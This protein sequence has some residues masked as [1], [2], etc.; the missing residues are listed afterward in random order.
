MPKPKPADDAVA[1]ALATADAV[2]NL[3]DV[4]GLIH[5]EIRTSNGAQRVGAEGRPINT[6]LTSQKLSSSGGRLAGWSVRETS[7][8][9]PAV[10]RL[11]DGVDA[12]GDIL[13]TIA[14]AANQG[15]S[16]SMP[17]AGV[18][19]ALGLFLELVS[20][21]VEGAVWIGPTG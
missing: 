10:L 4:L 17:G 6:A 12:G 1:Q 20:G 2:A 3:N 15:N 14:L 7:G 21:V 8:A 19:F 9:A 16:I 18:G 13:A 5:N 11:R